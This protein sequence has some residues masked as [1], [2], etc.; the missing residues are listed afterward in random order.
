MS[1]RTFRSRI[2][3]S[4]VA[5]VAG[6]STLA[7]SVLVLGLVDAPSGDAAPSAADASSAARSKPAA[8]APASTAATKTLPGEI[9]APAHV[10]QMITVTSAGWSTTRARLRAWQ[11][12]DNG[13]WRLVRGPIP[14]RIGYRGWVR[15]EKRQQSTGTS[16]AGRYRLPY[17]FG[18]LA[19]PGAH[20]NYRRFDRT[21]WWPYEPRDPDT[22]NV[23]QWHK[24]AITHWRADKAEHLWDYRDQYAFAVVVGFNLP[25]GIRY[26][27][28]QRQWVAD[29]RADTSR[30]GGIFLHVNGSGPTAGCVSMARHRI[31][32]IVRWL[33]PAADPQIVMGPYRYVV[34]L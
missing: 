33:R 2:T 16:P 18:R 17:A 31:R 9:G 11:R 19:D 7:A 32:W 27:H 3:L 12:R 10:K 22:Y 6:V 4:S 5:G 14:V 8:P 20:L 34:N 13:H 15:G 30:G 23:W 1:T 29:E 21:D 28:R 26:S 25:H 24:A